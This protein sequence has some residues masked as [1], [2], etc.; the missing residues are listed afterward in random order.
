MYNLWNWSWAEKLMVKPPTPV[1][2]A[3][4]LELGQAGKNPEILGP[5]LHHLGVKSEGMYGQ[6]AVLHWLIVAPYSHVS[7]PCTQHF[8]SFASADWKHPSPKIP[9]LSEI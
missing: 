9:L 3:T 1:K 8:C 5:L 7:L 4:C 6:A 2:G